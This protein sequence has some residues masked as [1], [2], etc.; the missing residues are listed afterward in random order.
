M[1]RNRK[2][3]VLRL[4]NSFNKIRANKNPLSNRKVS[5]RRGLLRNIEFS[6]FVIASVQKLLFRTGPPTTKT[7]QCPATINPM[8]INF[9]PD[10]Q[11]RSNPSSLGGPTN[12]FKFP[13]TE[14][15]I[16]TCGNVPFTSFLYLRKM[17]WTTVPIAIIKLIPRTND[18]Q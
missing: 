16:N 15:A 10:M 17:A 8:A 2:F 1:Y 14:K 6:I 18:L 13:T 3:T 4:S 12:F 9:I 5:T 7:R 11:S